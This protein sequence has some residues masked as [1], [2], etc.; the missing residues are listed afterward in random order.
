MTRFRGGGRRRRTRGG[1]PRRPGGRR[2]PGR[3]R[4]GPPGATAA[5]GLVGAPAPVTTRSVALPERVSVRDLAQLLDVGAT[6]VLK[7]LLGSGVMATINHEL[8]RETAVM[9]TERLGVEVEDADAEATNGAVGQAATASEAAVEQPPAEAEPADDDDPGLQPRAPV[10]AIMGHVDHGKTSLLDV[11]RET[12]VAEREVGGITQRIGAY[13]VTHQEQRITFLDTPGHEAFT[14]LRARGAQVTDIAVLVVAADD[15]VQ[16]QTVEAISHVRA[17]KVPFL[18]AIN[19]IDRPNARVDRVHQQLAE[20]DVVVEP[21]GGDVVAVPVS[22]VTKEGVDGLLEMVGLVAELEELRAD[23]DGPAE[24]IVVEA[25]LD[26]SQGPVATV[27]VQSGTL[28]VGN[29]LV[30]GE[31]GGRVRALLDEHGQRIRDAGPSVPVE[32]LGLAQVPEPGDR[33]EVADGDRTARKVIAAREEAR[34]A[35]QSEPPR[36]SL[37]DLLAQLNPDQTDELRVVLKADVHGSLEAIRSALP[38]LDTE[39]AKVQV[40][41][42]SVG[43]VSENDINLA[44]ASDGMILAFNMRPTAGIRRRAQ[45]QGVEIRAYEVIYSLLEDVEQALRQLGEPETGELVLGHAEIR[46]TFRA[47]GAAAVVG[48]YVQDGVVRRGGRARV[49]RQ[50][51]WVY[52]GRIASLRRFKDDVDEVPADYECGM[53]L[54]NFADPQN[55]DIIEVY[56]RERAPAKAG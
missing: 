18:V 56:A 41:Y 35:A 32:V 12:Q 31:V 44:A 50:G 38:K 46:A 54:E 48:C 51:S 22:A 17:A 14:A 47:S 36:R 5:G 7:E 52:D 13:Q 21:Y 23:P 27:L 19:K 55:G 40:L 39:S 25:R 43:G 4:R 10:V 2:R 9:V 8:D 16:P 1:G 30:I 45:Q 20:H 6:A 42:S 33:L 15:G 28:A 3:R 49:R 37:E 29:H 34:R 53:G 26:R 11:I 24:G